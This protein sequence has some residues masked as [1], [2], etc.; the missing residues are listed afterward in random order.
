MT[1]VLGIGLAEADFGLLDEVRAGVNRAKADEVAR[2]VGLTDRE[3]ARILNLSERTF[4]RLQAETRLDSNASERLLL[5]EK[6][7]EHG[8]S[9]F[10]DR[11]AVLG[12]WL[13]VPLPELRRQTPMA[14][15]DTV[16]G[17]GMVH[18][19]LGRIEWGIYA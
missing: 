10:D 19:V 11:A 8:L 14:L 13:R 9:V 1:A 15:L 3:M 5:L 4:H 7:I 18:T 6:L 17:F 2:L 16:T 12:R